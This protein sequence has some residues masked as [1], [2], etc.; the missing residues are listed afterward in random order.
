MSSL[1]YVLT[2]GE[3]AVAMNDTNITVHVPIP[4]KK[5]FLPA[6]WIYVGSFPFRLALPLQDSFDFRTVLI[7][8]MSVLFFLLP[9]CLSLIEYLTQ[10]SYGPEGISVRFLGIP[11]RRIPWN[12]VGHAIYA[13]AWRDPGYPYFSRY[14]HMPRLGQI[15]Y[16]TL[17]PSAGFCPDSDIRWLHRLLHP[18]TSFCIFLPGINVPHYTQSFQAYYP[19]LRRQTQE[20][21]M[22]LGANRYDNIYR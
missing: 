15:I 4:W 5:L 14:R 9:G 20:S 6:F 8:L 17:P 1:A 2:D 13:F 7:L 16:V 10:Y 19:K 3:M 22:R 21:G 18:F 12:R 11:I